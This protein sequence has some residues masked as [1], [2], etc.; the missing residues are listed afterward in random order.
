VSV[1]RAALPIVVD[2]V[3]VVV[4]A[5]VGMFNHDNDHTLLN[6]AA[7]VWPFLLGLAAGWVGAIWNGLRG[8]RIWPGGLL[9]VAVTYGTGMA[10]RGVSGRGLETGFLVFSACF[11]VVTM[12]GWRG[13][14][15]LVRR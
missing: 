3:I 7:I 5:T 2:V 12:L 14:W 15:Q 6:L 8:L 11:F 1:I 10:F 9:I 13:V 4:F